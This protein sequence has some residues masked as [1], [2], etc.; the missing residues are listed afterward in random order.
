MLA[1]K[2][3]LPLDN[4]SIIAREQ[5]GAV[6][7]SYGTKTQLLINK[8]VFEDAFRRRR[9]LS[10]CFIDYA[11]AYDSVPHKWIL[12]ILAI[13]KINSIILSFLAHSMSMWHT[14]MS[15]Y[16]ENGVLCVNDIMIKRGIFQGDTLSPLLFIIAINPLSLLLNRKC[17][18]YSLGGLNVTH[19]LYMD[20]LKG[21]C[22]S[23]VNIKKMVLLIERFS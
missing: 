7:K 23:Y 4:H 3:S 14:N 15:L 2:I 20:D 9:N 1:E 10:M 11:K 13:Y 21:F 6:K 12:E 16:H 18:G 5:Q 17:S 8:S 22:S 19:T